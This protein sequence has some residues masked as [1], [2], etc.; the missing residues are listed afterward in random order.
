MSDV[1]VIG[2]LVVFLIAMNSE[3]KQSC[4]IFHVWLTVHLELY[5]IMNQ[6]DALFFSLITLPR[7][8]V[9]GPFVAHHQEAEC[10]V[11]R[12][13]LVL[14]A[15]LHNAKYFFKSVYYNSGTLTAR[16]CRIISKCNKVADKNLTQLNTFDK[17]I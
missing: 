1:T 9:S 2:V 11:W 3:L 8:H 6:H 15:F 7:L 17:C 13:V 5:C 10:I 4:L 16:S 14:H 12:M